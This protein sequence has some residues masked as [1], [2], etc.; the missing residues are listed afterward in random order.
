MIFKI[1]NK[2]SRLTKDNYLNYSD[3]Y[4]IS[5]LLIENY[6]IFTELSV[7]FLYHKFKDKSKYKYII[8][9]YAYDYIKS[10]RLTPLI[11]D[12]QYDLFI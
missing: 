11:T 12:F 2:I 6:N 7:Y 5:G 3:L 8:T 4:F 10:I 1:F 9:I